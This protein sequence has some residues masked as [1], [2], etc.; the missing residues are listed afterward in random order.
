MCTHFIHGHEEENLVI[1]IFLHVQCTSRLVLIF[2]KVQIVG[3]TTYR[4]MYI[5]VQVNAEEFYIH[6]I[7]FIWEVVP[8]LEFLRIIL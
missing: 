7:V 5:R 1:I 4:N 8:L 6:V 3:K 2:Q